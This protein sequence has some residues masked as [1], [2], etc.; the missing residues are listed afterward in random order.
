ME[1]PHTGKEKLTWEAARCPAAG[2]C[3]EGALPKFRTSS[4]VLGQVWWPLLQTGSW[5]LGSREASDMSQLMKLIDH[6]RGQDMDPDYR[7]IIQGSCGGVD[8]GQNRGRS[9]LGSGG[10]KR[11]KRRQQGSWPWQLRWGLHG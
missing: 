1:R 11:W 2:G 9:P 10:W 7:I 8:R 3:E 5:A 4:E 6:E